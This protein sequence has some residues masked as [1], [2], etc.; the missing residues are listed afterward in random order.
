MK[1]LG[2]RLLV[3]EGRPPFLKNGTSDESKIVI[4]ELMP[5]AESFWAKVLD[6]GNGPKTNLHVKT[7]E[8]V[9]CTRM[10]GLETKQGRIISLLDV[11]A[12]WEGA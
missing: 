3:E 10:G 5:K 9:F 1:I 4:P 7:G 11:I 12:K 2:E 8:W 6:A